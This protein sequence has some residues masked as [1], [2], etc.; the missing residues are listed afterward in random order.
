MGKK[1]PEELRM[2]VADIPKY[3]FLVIGRTREA[4]LTHPRPQRATEGLVNLFC[5]FLIGRNL[6]VTSASRG[7]SS[8]AARLILEHSKAKTVDTDSE[9]VLIATQIQTLRVGYIGVNG[10]EYEDWLKHQNEISRI[11]YKRW[12]LELENNP[13]EW[14]LRTR[15]SIRMIKQAFETRNRLSNVSMRPTCS[16]RVTFQ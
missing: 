16:A 2:V 15:F 11:G 4:F 6:D 7:L 10:L 8:R 3:D 12:M 13:K 1:Y 5:S 9:W 14:L